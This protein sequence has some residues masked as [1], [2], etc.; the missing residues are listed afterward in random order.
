MAAR[1]SRGNGRGKP[2][3]RQPTRRPRAT[4][5]EACAVAGIV[6]VC[7]ALLFGITV[8]VVLGGVAL[9]YIVA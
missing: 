9:V 5:G 3:R 6:A 1:Q 7:G 4:L 2:T 8:G